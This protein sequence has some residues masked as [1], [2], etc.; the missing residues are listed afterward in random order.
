[1]EYFVI[2]EGY[3]GCVCWVVVY[4]MCVVLWSVVEGCVCEFVVYYYVWEGCVGCYVFW[5][6]WIGNWVD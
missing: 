5:C 4:E 6:D 2:D 1:M 3:W